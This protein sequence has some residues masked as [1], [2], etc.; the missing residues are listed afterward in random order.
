[1]DYNKIIPIHLRQKLNSQKNM[2]QV[3]DR[4]EKNGHNIDVYR[5]TIGLGEIHLRNFSKEID[6][7]IAVYP[8]IKNKHVRFILHELII[9][10]QFSMLRE[11]VSRYQR[12]EKSSAYFNL[13]I[14]V[15]NGFFSAGIEEYG[16]YF[17]YQNYLENGCSIDEL[18]NSNNGWD[19]QT[20]AYD[21]FKG[22]SNDTIKLQLTPESTL[23]IPD[24]SNQLALRII[25]NATDHDFFVSLFY[26][27][28]KYM[29]KRIY[30]RIENDTLIKSNSLQTGTSKI[31]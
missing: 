3:R 15:S 17:D 26:K 6:S 1:M 12:N 22:I 24:S 25:E 28:G 31:S 29:W 27:N 2:L 19:V 23:V 5:Y 14:F 16:D 9:N 30:F 10:T 4:L 20:D 13:I 7:I 21:E 18:V 11:F 8:W